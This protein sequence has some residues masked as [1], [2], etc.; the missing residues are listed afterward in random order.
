MQSS[1][2][3]ADMTS[4]H[5]THPQH[6]PCRLHPGISI[7]W[8]REAGLCLK[9]KQLGR[10]DSYGAGRCRAEQSVATAADRRLGRQLVPYQMDSATSPSPLTSLYLVWHQALYG[11]H[12]VI[13]SIYCA[14]I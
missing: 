5:P 2:D 10:S 6:Q 9:T 12:G 11:S 13:C 4:F 3:N 8:Q 1:Q 7:S 14:L